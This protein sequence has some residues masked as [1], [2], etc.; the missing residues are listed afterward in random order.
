MHDRPSLNP[1][2]MNTPPS[3]VLLAIHW[4]FPPTRFFSNEKK[5]EEI[6]NKFNFLSAIRKRDAGQYFLSLSH[7]VEIKKNVKM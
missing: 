3:A 2:I 5:K 1:L 7:F 4:K 6:Q